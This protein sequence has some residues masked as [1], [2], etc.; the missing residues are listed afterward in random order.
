MELITAA[1]VEAADIKI[2]RSADMRYVGQGFEIVVPVP[3]DKLGPELLETLE[4]AFSSTYQSLF[5]RILSDIPVE[6]ITWRMSVS[7]PPPRPDIR[8]LTSELRTQ[9]EGVKG[10]RSLF[11]I[12]EGR[13]VDCPVF[14]RYGLE[15][16]ATVDGPAIVEE[17]ESTVF[18]GPEARFAIDEHLNLVMS[19]G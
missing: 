16:G 12:E 18:V 1:G 13:F 4:A 15:P 11:L 10:E 9:T 3:N 19:L 17:R 6:T 5:G 8:F 2:E 14:D 7:E